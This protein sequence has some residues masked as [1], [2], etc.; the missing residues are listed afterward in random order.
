MKSVTTYRKLKPN[1]LNGYSIE[2]ST[3]YSS[4]DQREIDALEENLEKTIGTML[5]TECTHG[6]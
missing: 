3:I 4:F 2:V 6:E 1:T 5:V